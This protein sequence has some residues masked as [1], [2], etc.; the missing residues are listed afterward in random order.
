MP[1]R[2]LDLVWS[3]MFEVYNLDEAIKRD[4][5][6]DVSAKQFHS[7]NYEPRKNTKIDHK[8]NEPKI[9][10]DGGYSLL[11]RGFDTWR[12]G[13]FEIFQKLPTWRF[14]GDEVKDM[15]WPSYIET[16]NPYEITGEPGALN[17]AHAAGIVEDFLGQEQVLTVSG[18]MR[19][20]SFEFVVDDRLTGKSQV[21]VSGAQIEIDGGFESRTPFG[22]SAGSPFTI[23]EVKN[24]ISP[25]FVT[26]QLFYPLATWKHNLPEKNIRTVFMTFANEIFDL[27]E[28]SFNQNDY[29]SATLVQHKRYSINLR[30]PKSSE[31]VEIAQKVLLEA[32]KNPPKGIPFPQAD[33]FGKVMDMLT[34]IAQ[35]PRTNEELAVEYPLTARQTFQY[36]PDACQYL[37][38]IEDGIN[39]YG[40]KVRQATKLGKSITKMSYRDST[41]KLA[42]LILRIPPILDAYL[43]LVKTGELPSVESIALDFSKSPYAIKA[44]DGKPLSQSTVERRSRTI[45]AW[46]NWLE[47]VAA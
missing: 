47:N 38:L 39:D 12:I 7:L 40:Q 41:L 16:I 19:T 14:P 36:Y 11:T 44:K 28:Y 34:F 35:E 27:F 25:D 43:H 8:V 29:S 15:P 18:R 1:E 30:K 13:S 20:P 2:L 21:Q 31:F 3:E 17:A 4:G 6:V 32:P 22:S 37:G 46:A 24:H 33:D 45:R 26:R 42:E 10:K 9:F 5:F 23:F